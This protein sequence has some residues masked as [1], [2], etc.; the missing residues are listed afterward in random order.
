MHLF[1]V[2]NIATLYLTAFAFARAEEPLNLPDIVVS[3]SATYNE[4]QQTTINTEF[5]RETLDVQN[6]PDLNSTLRGLSSV[7][8]SQGT[9]GMA[10]NVILRGASGGLGLINFDGVPLFD[11]FTGF[12]QLSHFPLDLLNNVSVSRG[13]NGEQNSS[14]TLGGSINL[15]SRKIS[16]NKAFLHT[17][18]GSYGTLRNNL[19]AGTHN[20]L[21]DW[22]FAGGR[23][24]IFEGI[25]QA[26]PENGG[27]DPKSSQITNGML[28]WQKDLNKLSF[29]TSLY[30]VESRDGFDG[31]GVLPNQT[32]GWKS[33]PN[34]LVN[35]QTWVTQNRTS[36]QI[37][38]HWETAL[39]FGYTQ[40]K[41]TGRSGTIPH[42]CSM[43]L[44][45]QLWLGNWQNTHQFAINYQAKD[46]LK[47]I[48]GI[49]T[50][51]QQGDSIDNSA[52][53]HTLS[54]Q[55]ISPLARTELILGDWLAG[56]EVR[57]DHYDSYGDHAVFNANIGWQFT[58][59]MLVWI[60]GGTGY[61]APAVNELLHP[62]FG[63]LNQFLLPETNPN[64]ILKPESNR[65]GEVGWRWHI[66]QKSEL[67]L[68]GYVQH[69]Q[70]LIVLEQDINQRITSINVEQAHIWGTEL[71]AKHQWTHQW[72]SG[73]SYSYME[74]DNP[75]TGLAL[76]GR[77]KNQGKFW[78][79][80]Q[81]IEPLVLKL[82]LTYRDG[83]ALNTNN[84]LHTQAAPRLNAN[85]NYQ[86]NPKLAVYARGE[87][88]NNERT[89]DLIGFNYMGIGI[90]GGIN[91][92]Y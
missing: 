15:F 50:Q 39:K 4:T 73:L 87:N 17:E 37:F 76:P 44:T 18:G 48:W 80:Y 61:R 43:D 52:K 47:I 70:N 6:K 62:L 20:K 63:N 74:A 81:V 26:S 33:D 3:S 69:Y 10:T 12:F 84:V 86:I 42:C 19:G 27:N 11:S 89:P 67:S 71:Q 49:D 60:K 40:D 59:D 38:D 56:A 9:L 88:L 82:D 75:K 5:N 7:G 90:Y 41:Q 85:I 83:Y 28:N 58:K 35:Q 32:I 65:G 68:S 29:D 55:L 14:R 64:L 31:L 78:T 77:P 92:N 57:Y 72:A 36:Y 54:T 45:S 91:F 25:S 24:D 16:D 51:H 1:K 8:I 22:S 34:G 46:A 21:G 66:N 2:L 79:Q 53:S 13:F 30:F 23:S